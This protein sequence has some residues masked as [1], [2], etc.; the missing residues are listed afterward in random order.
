M[1]LFWRK[2]CSLWIYAI[3]DDE[4]VLV[5]GDILGKLNEVISEIG[6]SKEILIAGDFNSRVGRKINNQVLGSFGKKEQIIMM[7]NW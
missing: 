5:K 6:N 7:I 2:L 3:S 4:N 1:N